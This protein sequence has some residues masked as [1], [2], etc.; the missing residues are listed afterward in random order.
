[1]RQCTKG[2]FERKGLTVTKDFEKMIMFRICPKNESDSMYKI[3]ND[4]TNETLRNSFSIDIMKCSESTSKKCKN[5]SEI[6]AFLKQVYFTLYTIEAK[7][8]FD[9]NDERK[10]YK[11][12]KS[13][14]LRITDKFHSQF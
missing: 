11:T 6:E 3:T 7:V 4:Y 5:D 8:T 14:I 1:M 13:A 10:Q 12:S 9:D 2:D